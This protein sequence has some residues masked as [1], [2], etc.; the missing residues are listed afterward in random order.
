MKIITK[1][2][3]L[4][5][6]LIAVAVVNLLVLYNTQTSAVTES[7]SIIRAGDL[8]TKTETIA[9]LTISVS[10]GKESDR[11]ILEKEIKE[12]D[13]VLTTLKIGGTI[14]D[15]QISPI[16]DDISN[17]YDTVVTNWKSYSSE[18]VG[19]QSLHLYNKK[20]V[21]SINYILDKNTELILTADALTK[22]LETLDRDYNEH[23]NIAA[24]LRETAKKIGQDALLVSLDQ[25]ENAR[26]NLQH[27]KTVFDVGLRKLQ[28]Q[29]LD[30]FDLTGTSISRD[31]I[32]LIPRENSKSLDELD[33]LWESIALRI[34]TVETESLYSEED[35][36]V[37]RMNEQRQNLLGSLD[38]FL[39]SWNADRIER[40]NNNLS[41]TGIVSAVDV[42]VFIAV[43][44]TIRY[45][46]RP[47]EIITGALAKVR[48]GIYGEKINYSAKDEVGELASSFNTMTETIKIKEEEARKTDI[49]KDEFLAMITHEL[50][51]PLV[52]IRGYA[53]I[54]LGGHLGELTDKQKERI[55]IIKS[56]ASSLLQLISDL[57][58]VQKL[59]LGQLKIQKENLDIYDTAVKSIQT[60]QPQ[61]EEDRVNIVND[62]GHLTILH[63]P[64]RIGQVLT[65]LIKNSLKA[66]K[67]GTGMIRVYSE[68]TPDAVKIMVTDNGA[69]IA[70]DRQSKLFTKFYQADASMTREKG[71][72][73]LGLSICKGIIEIHGGKISMQSTPNTGTTVTFTLP[74]SDHKTAI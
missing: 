59:E 62:V 56:S 3:L 21:D 13:T 17:D 5:A 12:F 33:L 15:Q 54:L 22:D 35:N 39:D 57:L 60:L 1:T 19:V 16:P 26:Q 51:T 50:K 46:L 66:V 14:R 10:N 44:L 49:A 74:K 65:N 37:S 68:Q 43:L 18:V 38:V 28:Q 11:V 32:S 69:G 8:K 7:Y 53:D 41:I 2:Y 67:P 40:R 47:L 30:G 24:S 45:S 58:D 55:E 23:K 25:D 48:E 63:D 64:D 29:S 72:S 52:P 42:S 36:P 61:I 70:Y 27:D 20:V 4:V 6:V 9:S 34:K 71:G 31:P 73:G